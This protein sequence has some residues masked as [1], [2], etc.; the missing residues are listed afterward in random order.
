LSLSRYYLSGYRL[1]SKT[2]IGGTIER[3]W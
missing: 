2:G 1:N 3:L